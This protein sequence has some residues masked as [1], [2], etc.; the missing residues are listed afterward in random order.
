MKYKAYKYLLNEGET[1]EDLISSLKNLRGANLR[2]ANLREAN[3]RGANLNG[4]DLREADLNGAVLRGANLRGA[5]LDFPCLPLCCGSFDIKCDDNFVGQII[6]HLLKL[7]NK[8]IKKL[9]GFKTLTN[10]ANKSN[11]IEKHN[12]KG[13]K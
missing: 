10:L 2:G 3:L 6:Y 5:D 11:I 8:N 13:I 12:L 7:D 4:A 9:R 1:F